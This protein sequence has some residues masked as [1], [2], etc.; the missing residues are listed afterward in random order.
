MFAAIVP[1]CAGLLVFVFAA[2]SFAQL[3]DVLRGDLHIDLV[4]VVEDIAIDQP[5]LLTRAND[6]SGRRFLV[7]KFGKIYRLGSEG[8][9][10]GT[11]FLD[12]SAEVFTS[13]AR[14][15]LGLV[16]HSDF[17]DPQSP[18]YRKIY[19]YHSS[20]D[21]SPAVDFPAP[22]TITHHNILTEWQVS[23]TD[24][25]QVDV[26]TRREVFRE[27]HPGANHSGGG[28][29]FGP[30][31]YLY[32]SIGT[33]VAARA[34]EL[35]NVLGKFLRID[36]LDPALTPTSP[37]LAS[38][39]GKYRIAAKNPF[40]SDPMGMDEI[41]AYGL[42]HP[43]RFSFDPLNGRLFVGDV[44]EG[45]IEEVDVI[46]H[47]K[48]YGWPYFEGTIEGPASPP[49]PLPPVEDPIA[50]Y[51][52]DDGRSVIG[53]YVYRGS[54]IP[55]LYGKYVFG[56]LTRGTG[57]FTSEPGRV[58][59]FDPYDEEGNLKDVSEVEVKEMIIG[60]D[61]DDPQLAIFSLGMD[62]QGE[63]YLVGVGTT[64]GNKGTVRRIVPF[65]PLVGDMDCDNDIDF[66]DI[67]AFVLGLNDAAAYEA[68]FGVPPSKKGDVD[69]DGDMDFDD[70]PPFVSLFSNAS[71][72]D[73]ASVPEP[74]ALQGTAM[75]IVCLLYGL[76]KRRARSFS[77][78]PSV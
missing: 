35:T 51:D 31:G 75:G 34:Q 21:T 6:G 44:G 28:M 23:S 30:D 53:G 72:A 1:L 45:N 41:Y 2:S 14:G 5:L 63:L 29:E 67:S 10:S 7:D 4:T 78:L 39:N 36:P 65:V 25:N 24:P 64:G 49:D 9:V 59:W 68:M 46:E 69:R 8:G 43:Y 70:I 71:A 56:D 15:L 47:G 66:D 16:F 77:C 32:L 27:A 17:A 38:S 74:T 60:I 42:R 12:L 58:F 73:A 18:G 22:G 19:T 20:S 54:M 48:N 61:G 11:P 13:G 62:E 37:D 50:Q 3:P 57:P 26:T 52:H 33:P 76:R 55:E 40:V